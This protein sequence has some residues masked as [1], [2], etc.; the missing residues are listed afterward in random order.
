[1]SI[2]RVDKILSYLEE[3]EVHVL[4]LRVGDFPIEMDTDTEVFVKN[5]T[6][7][8]QDDKFKFKQNDK[9]ITIGDEI[10]S[11]DLKT[12]GGGVITVSSEDSISISSGSP[13]IHTYA[14]LDSS[15]EPKI[16][17]AWKAGLHQLTV[18]SPD[19]PPSGHPGNVRGD[20][21]PNPGDIFQW[22]HDGAGAGIGH[23]DSIGAGALGPSGPVFG[24]VL[25]WGGT[26]WVASGITPAVGDVLH[27]DGSGWSGV[28]LSSAADNLGNHIATKNLQMNGFG[29]IFGAHTASDPHII[30][31][32]DSGL[33]IKTNGTRRV[34][35]T[36][37]GK[38]GFGV[39]SD[40]EGDGNG[41][42]NIVAHPTAFDHGLYIDQR[43]SSGAYSAI[44][45]VTTGRGIRATRDNGSH[46]NL[47]EFV[48]ED[49]SATGATLF[50]STDGS[51][52]SIIARSNNTLPRPV[53]TTGDDPTAKILNGATEGV[54][55]RLGGL[56]TLFGD[57]DDIALDIMH[58]VSGLSMGP[59]AELSRNC[60]AIDC[61]GRAPRTT[62]D[63]KNHGGF[64]TSSFYR[65]T[66]GM[67]QIAKFEYEHYRAFTCFIT[68]KD[69]SVAPAEYTS[70][71]VQVIH[72]GT[73][74][75]H[76]E[77][78][79]L[80]TGAGSTNANPVIFS[81]NFSVV[82][83]TFILRM[84]T[85][86]GTGLIDGTMVVTALQGDLRDV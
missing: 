20:M 73:S 56:G 62:I 23:W 5:G 42:A 84:A 37:S 24:D 71:T 39:W 18:D 41:V 81:T 12:D 44:D 28:P 22:N 58:P 43:S 2:L 17:I 29:V 63:I 75:H 35:I 52:S 16:G 3:E 60:M 38:V 70:V 4:G 86:A 51:G 31:N 11:L 55:L 27:W 77:Y 57:P 25:A 66:S 59:T 1:M 13:A 34:E 9:W 80:E 85:P 21:A 14:T 82:S 30:D 26:G 64:S 61:D 72:D 48:D 47:A 54:V 49:S 32:S 36:P 67:V 65:E 6:C 79:R 68:T 10:F 8:Y 40:L 74:T 53:A 46:Y 33:E 69:D 15:G 19:D 50:L 45:V 7:V 78:G 76:V 83:G